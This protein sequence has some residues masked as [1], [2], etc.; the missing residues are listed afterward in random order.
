M[1]AVY[2]QGYFADIG[3]HVFPMA[4]YRLVRDALIEGG[5]LRDED[6]LQPSPASYEDL[7]LVHT[8]EY[9]GKLKEGNL[10]VSEQMILELPF[11]AELFSA[12]ILMTGGTIAASETAL[13]EGIS[14]NIGGGFHHAF[15]DH[16]EGFC[17]LNDVAVA[18]KKALKEDRAGKVLIIDC[19][20]H[21][22]NGTAFIFA[23]EKNVFTFSMHQENNYPF[24][25]PPGDMDI[26]LRDFARDGE[27][28][29]T[30][31]GNLGE[32]IDFGPELAFYL[33]GADIYE[34]DRL[35]GLKITAGGIAKRD[36]MVIRALRDKKIPAAVVLAGGYAACTGQTCGI[37][38]RTVEICK[39]IAG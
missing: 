4:K 16:G 26:G 11:T 24:H 7:L 37:H 19:D 30:L 21:H 33:A 39:G 10:D 38:C 12:N 27:Y 18:V 35:G 5:I 15:P 14:V 36:E 25:K 1:K 6:F 28:L 34:H 32:C 17:M 20:L 13:R 9:L 22:G 29:R 31:G 23:E 8:E 3:E 2:S